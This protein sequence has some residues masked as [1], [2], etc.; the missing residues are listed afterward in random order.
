MN[1]RKFSGLALIAALCATPADA[2]LT[3]QSRA[4]LI[5]R[6][7]SL[8]SDH[9]VFP[10]KAASIATT[11]RG[12]KRDREITATTDERRLASIL[13]ERLRHFDGHFT[14]RFSPG[15]RADAAPDTDFERRTNYGFDEVRRLPGNIGYIRLS[16]FADFDVTL[17]G[18]NLPPA[19]K[20][21]EAALALVANCDAVV[22]DLRQNGGGSSTMIDLLL[23]GFFGPRPV[24]L[25]R[26]HWRDGN[27]NEDTSTLAN[28]TGTRRPDVPLYVLTSARSASAAEEF[29]YDVQ[30]QHRGTL[31]GETTAGAANPGDTF[32]AGGGFSIFI[33]TGTAINPVTG[34]NWERTGVHPDIAIAADDALPRAEG[35]A[36]KAILVRTA[37]GPAETA[38][39]WAM[40]QAESQATHPAT[41]SLADFAGRYGDRSVLLRE[42]AL[43]YVRGMSRRLI[44]L[45]G[46][47]FGIADAPE[48]RLT[49]RRGGTGRVES[50]SLSD[51]GG[52]TMLFARS[53][54]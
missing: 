10:D 29:S 1:L 23:S 35:E 11:M 19:R 18:T 6:T 24:L 46:D 40:E 13:T 53:A 48:I 4:A 3:A 45:G 44:P 47:A 9:Y 38:I 8:I 15:T 5:E 51:A 50:L 49:F 33:S 30:T 32:D 17:T 39:R 41:P 43:Y 21:A 2:A 36:L 31:V 37:P 12:W 25:N 14:L 16:Y 42:G 22:I 54:D 27:R 7:A 28:F 52:G 20:A 34:T 26:F